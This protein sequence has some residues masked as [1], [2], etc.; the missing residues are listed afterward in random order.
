MSADQDRAAK[1]RAMIDDPAASEGEKTNA[2][3][4]LGRLKQRE[5]LVKFHKEHWFVE[6]GTLLFFVCGGFYVLRWLFG[7]L[8]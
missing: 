7:G 6:I 8:L 1:L 3:A 4:A 5:A 2:R